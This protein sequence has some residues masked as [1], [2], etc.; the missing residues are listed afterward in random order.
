[1]D[2]ATLL[3]LDR[4]ALVE[5]VLHLVAE[6]ATALAALQEQVAA[7][8]RENAEL[9]ARLGQ[10]SSNSSRPPSSD[11]PGTRRATKPP[12]SGRAP[13]GQPGHPSHQRVLVPLDQVDHVIL[14][15]PAV[16]R[17]CGE[18]LPAT[19]GLGDPADERQQVTELPPPGAEVTEYQLAARRCR[20]CGT[21]TRASRPA[22]VGA[23]SFG[24]RLQALV[25]LLSGRYRLSRREV[26]QLLGDVWGAAV[27]LG[28]VVELEQ[29]T[30][31]ALAPVV[32]EAHT[33]AQH[34]T[35][36]NVD[37]TGWREGRRKA[38]LWVM[39]TTVLT[40]FRVGPGPV[41]P[42]CTRV[43]GADLARDCW[44]RSVLRLRLVGGALAPSL[45]GAPQA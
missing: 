30:S 12:L 38:W 29:A 22:E 6:Q 17:Q 2:R 37:E 15:V 32:A 8:H 25:A 39:V 16:C 45:L 14:L 24:P 31:A 7:L 20:G 19:V 9:R 23:G 36:A 44:L 33:M 43:A 35:V 4:E 11:L 1:M 21:V 28:S 41:W 10:N 18:V 34:A 26:V 42:D 40:V 13:G 27:A 5:L 3:T